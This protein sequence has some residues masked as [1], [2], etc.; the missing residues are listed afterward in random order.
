MMGWWT[1]MMFDFRPEDAGKVRLLT[2][3]ALAVAFLI[4]VARSL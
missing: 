4:A 2:F 1:A 3:V